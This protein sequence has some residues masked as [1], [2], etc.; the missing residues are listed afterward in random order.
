[1]SP[2]RARA[3]IALASGNVHKAEEWQ[4]LLPGW[5][6]STLDMSKAPAE[7][8]A[9]FTENARVK[10]CHGTTL[11]QPDWWV[12]GEDSGLAVDALDGAP[13]IRSARYAGPCASDTDNVVRLLDELA[14]VEDRRARFCCAAVCLSPLHTTHRDR[15]RRRERVE[16]CVEGTL[17]GDIGTASLGEAG[18]GYDPVFVPDGESQTVAELGAAWK[19]ANSHRASAATQL[20]AMLD[21][22]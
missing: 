6:V 8:G 12:L 14:G 5:H 21:R 13:G 17:E 4:T 2:C 16:L 10:A 15:S 18:F 7:T 9:T 19:E 1:M 20:L 22:W 3:T 11:A